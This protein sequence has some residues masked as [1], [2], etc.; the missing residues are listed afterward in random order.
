MR[1]GVTLVILLA[2]C[3]LGFSA[4]LASAQGVWPERAPYTARV[5]TDS[6]E[7]CQHLLSRIG[8]VRAQVEEPARR[9][10]MLTAEG[11]Q[12]CAHGHVRPG[13]ARLRRALLLLE[14]LR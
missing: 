5:T 10:D 3:C 2:G 9:A 7:Y 13:I 4:S 6:E 14:D 11:R 8:R 12:M 1:V